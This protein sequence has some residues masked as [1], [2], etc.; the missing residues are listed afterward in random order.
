MRQLNRFDSLL[1]SILYLGRLHFI[2]RNSTRS[3]RACIRPS[4]T[5][6]LTG[7][8]DSSSFLRERSRPLSQLKVLRRKRCVSITSIPFVGDPLTGCVY[9][10]RSPLRFC[11]KALIILPIC[12]SELA[13][14]RSSN[15]PLRHP[16]DSFPRLEILV[17]ANYGFLPSCPRFSRA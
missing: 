4:M 8:P 14:S 6:S 17:R 16:F 15:H 12:S 10:F 11:S 7:E 13:G 9:P 2:S 3:S 5:P 1:T